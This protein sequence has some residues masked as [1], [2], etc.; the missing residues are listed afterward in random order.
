MISLREAS[1]IVGLSPGRLRELARSGRLPARKV[2]RDWLVDHESVN[3]LPNERLPG[4]PLSGSSA[5]GLLALLSGDRPVGVDR[6]HRKR[7]ER[8]LNQ[9]ERALRLIEQSQPRAS[10]RR[11]WV[12]PDDLPRLS[13][14]IGLVPSG[15]SALSADFDVFNFERVFDAYLDAARFRSVIR[16]FQ[17]LEGSANPNVW[18]RVPSLRWV[19][20]H[21]PKAPGP[22]VAA[23]LLA[24][25]DQRVRAAGR[26]HLLRAMAGRG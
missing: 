2:G 1:E 18:L 17:P 9:P 7:V 22:V 23:D 19:L 6:H 16:R 26:G 4:R 24:S 25:S 8:L 13:Q 14:E 12:P 15:L 5:W 10:V 3:A 11:F 20:D 21:G